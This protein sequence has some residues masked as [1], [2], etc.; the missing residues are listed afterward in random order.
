MGVRTPCRGSARSCGEDRRVPRAGTE[1]SQIPRSVVYRAS[2]VFLS[3]EVGAP[4]AH[5]DH[6]QRAC[7]AALHLQDE[8]RGYLKEAKALLEELG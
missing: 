8:L 2:T 7:Y 6:A 5:E 3:T 1:T 4:I